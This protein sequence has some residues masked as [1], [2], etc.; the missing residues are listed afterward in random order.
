MFVWRD[1]DAEQARYRKDLEQR[2]C[3][4]ELAFALRY[5]V[6]QRAQ[7]AW[8][9]EA[10]LIE[11]GRAGLIAQSWEPARNDGCARLTMRIGTRRKTERR[12]RA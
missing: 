9:L 8:H 4:P 11:A 2:G 12:Y 7:A 5:E 1:G 3:D 10:V 6:Q